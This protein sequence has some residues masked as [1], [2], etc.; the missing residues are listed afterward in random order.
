MRNDEGEPSTAAARELHESVGG[1]R[2]DVERAEQELVRLRARNTDLQRQIGVVVGES[3]NLERELL[4]K[5]SSWRNLDDANARAEEVLPQL[6]AVTGSLTYRLVR[7]VL[8]V[9]NRVLGVLTLR[10][11]RR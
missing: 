3:Q 7:G 9:G 5:L 2:A 1:A 4:Q 11:L 10:F 8:H 6:R